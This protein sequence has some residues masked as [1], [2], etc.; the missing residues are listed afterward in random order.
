[1][2]DLSVFQ[3]PVMQMLPEA[4][5]ARL[6]LLSVRRMG[7]HGLDDAGIENAFLDR[8]GSHYTR[9]LA[10]MRMFMAELAR[11]SRQ[12]IDIAPCC[13]SRMTASENVLLG[14]LARA[15]RNPEAAHL[16]LTDLLGVRAAPAVLAGARAVALAFAEAGS[17]LD[18]IG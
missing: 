18:R 12:T 14:A 6:L 13:C 15:G 11:T 5:D 2:T 10:F 16:L 9:P 8:F 4:R 7:A 17:P 3:L 1:M